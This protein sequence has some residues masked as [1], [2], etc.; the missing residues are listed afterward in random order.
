M[1]PALTLEEAIERI[2]NFEGSPNEFQLAISD[3]LQDPVGMN[4]AII[5][6]KILSRNWE[7]DSFEEKDGHRVYFYK[8]PK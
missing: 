7:P 2:E 4:M 3:E 8:E 1:N 6:G 5:T